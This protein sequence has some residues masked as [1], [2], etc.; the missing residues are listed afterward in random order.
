MRICLISS[1][2][3]KGSQPNEPTTLVGTNRGYLPTALR[4]NIVLRTVVIATFSLALSMTNHLTGPGSASE[5]A[6]EATPRWT[7][8]KAVGTPEAD[9]VTARFT[10]VVIHDGRQLV[11][12]NN[13]ARFERGAPVGTLF[14]RYADGATLPS[15]PGDFSFAFPKAGVDVAG[16]LHLVWGEAGEEERPS[17]TRAWMTQ[18]IRQLWAASWSSQS[19]SWTRPVRIFSTRMLPLSWNSTVPDLKPGQSGALQ[20]EVLIPISEGD[21]RGRGGGVSQLLQLRL[22]ESGWNGTSVALPALA[23]YASSWETSTSKHIAYV[24]SA[25]RGSESNKVVVGVVDNG[26]L[27]HATVIDSSPVR[28]GVNGLVAIQSQEGVHLLWRH[29]RTRRNEVLRERFMHS[30]G[31]WSGPRDLDPTHRWGGE[32]VAIDE[33]GKVHAVFEAIGHDGALSQLTASLDT[34]W[35]TPQPL[36]SGLPGHS[37]HLST[38]P[39]GELVLSFAGLGRR[40]DDSVQTDTYLSTFAAHPRFVR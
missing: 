20:F 33:C 16:V 1:Q 27:T 23:L 4:G 21:S 35:S 40:D 11:V 38:L 31:V 8:P 13:L 19:G 3:L 22:G 7:A 18:S 29:A 14:M 15:P 10:G 9:P 2:S 12:G 39:T 24:G 32:T 5:S 6:C 28:G 37:A 26:E 34:A 17:S 25:V 36:F 30:D